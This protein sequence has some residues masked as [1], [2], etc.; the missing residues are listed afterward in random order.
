PKHRQRFLCEVRVQGHNYVGAGN[1]TTKKDAQSN[2]AKDFVQY[3]VRQGVVSASDVPSELAASVPTMDGG[4]G[5]SG[6]FRPVFAAGQTPDVM[7][8][9]YTA[10]K[11]EYGRDEGEGGR[12]HTYLDV[13]ADQKTVEEAEEV[14]MNAAIHG[15]WTVE[16]AKSKLHQYLQ[17]NKLNHCDYKYQVVGPDHASCSSGTC[18][19]DSIHRVGDGPFCLAASPSC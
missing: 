1:S 7:G 4:S 6:I 11:R 19:L 15:N 9:A 17:L 10:V 2:A 14:D 18:S 3:L 13:L 16:N 12:P 8:A 5:S